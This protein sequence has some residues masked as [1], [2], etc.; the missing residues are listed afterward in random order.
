MQKRKEQN[1]NENTTLIKMMDATLEFVMKEVPLDKIEKVIWDNFW[2][3]GTDADIEKKLGLT[4]LQIRTKRNNIYSK[5][6][7]QLALNI[8]AGRKLNQ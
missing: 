3:G 7:Y 2:A 6:G 4:K 8:R 5:I 1:M